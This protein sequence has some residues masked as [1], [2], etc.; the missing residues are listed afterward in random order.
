MRR[1]FFRLVD[2]ADEELVQP[3]RENQ[4]HRRQQIVVDRRDD[5]ADDVAV[6]GIVSFA[7]MRAKRIAHRLHHQRSDIDRG[8]HEE[9]HRG[10]E[11]RHHRKK[12]DKAAL[13]EKSFEKPFDCFHSTV[14]SFTDSSSYSMQPAIAR[15][16]PPPQ[17]HIIRYFQSM[18]LQ[19]GFLLDVG[20]LGLLVSQKIKHAS[21]EPMCVQMNC[22]SQMVLEACLCGIFLAKDLRQFNSIQL[23][24]PR[25]NYDFQ[26][27]LNERGHNRNFNARVSREL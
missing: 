10:D 16:N 3:Q 6:K 21:C 17:L 23:P 25:I 13:P 1:V 11:A 12:H 5:V 8:D 15:G 4:E 24:V 27:D 9:N 14:P 2:L 26:S 19:Y 22:H 7:A 18:P 20:F